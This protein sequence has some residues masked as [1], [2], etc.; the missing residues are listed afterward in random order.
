[1]G[2]SDKKQKYDDLTEE[3]FKDKKDKKKLIIKRENLLTE[4][5]NDK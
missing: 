2:K 1:M 4:E 3:K 5:E